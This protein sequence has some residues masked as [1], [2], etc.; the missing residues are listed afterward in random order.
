MQ[1]VVPLTSPSIH[2]QKWT[3]QIL[4]GKWTGTELKMI[5]I[6]F[7]NMHTDKYTYGAWDRTGSWES[8]IASKDNKPWGGLD[9]KKKKTTDKATLFTL[10][11]HLGLKCH[12]YCHNFALGHGDLYMC[13]R[14]RIFPSNV[15]KK[16][17]NKLVS[18]SQAAAFCVHQSKNGKC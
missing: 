13:P 16:W 10:E 8:E 1:Q 17:I 14:D 12:H 15:E 5:G 11:S 4:Y 7:L 9:K 6:M 18:P 2:M 3:D